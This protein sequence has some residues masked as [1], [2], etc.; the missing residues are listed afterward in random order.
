MDNFTLIWFKD[1]KNNYL[2]SLG[3]HVIIGKVE[4]TQ[5]HKENVL[6]CTP[7]AYADQLAANVFWPEGKVQ[8]LFGHSVWR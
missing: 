6:L 2:W 7:N 5:K 8:W 1:I 4:K 3:L